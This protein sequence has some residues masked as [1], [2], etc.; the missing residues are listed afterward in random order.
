MRFLTGLLMLSGF[1]TAAVRDCGAEELSAAARRIAANKAKLAEL[2]KEAVKTGQTVADIGSLSIDDFLQLQAV[3]DGLDAVGADALAHADESM[4]FMTA[5][6]AVDAIKVMRQ[7]G[8]ELPDGLEDKVKKDPDNASKLMM[9]A[10]STIA[11]SNASADEIKAMRRKVMRQSE[12][13]LGFSF[14]SIVDNQR[15]MMTS[16]KNKKKK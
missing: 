5:N 9:E 10:F 6:Q 13:T 4:D 15:K 11:P 14:K 16:V 12:N 2:D 8:I 3:P 1:L 7:N